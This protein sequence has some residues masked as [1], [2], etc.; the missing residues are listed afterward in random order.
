[1]NN[2]KA[3]SGQVAGINLIPKYYHKQSENTK[4]FLLACILAPFVIRFVWWACT[5]L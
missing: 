5:G 4:A 2:K 1:M 3:T